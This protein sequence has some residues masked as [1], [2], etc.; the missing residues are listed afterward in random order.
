MLE[1]SKRELFPVDWS[2]GKTPE[3][4]I[5][6]LLKTKWLSIQFF[7]DGGE[8]GGAGGEGG[9]QTGVDLHGDADRAAGGSSSSDDLSDVIYGIGG[10]GGAETPE[11][12]DAG[13]QN[14]EEPEDLDAE[15]E[16]LIAKD[17]K[18]RAI[19]E[20]KV[21][22]IV[23]SRLRSMKQAQSPKV[24]TE[25]DPNVSAMMSELAKKYKVDAGDNAAIAK[26]FLEDADRLE[27][28]AMARGITT[29][30]LKRQKANERELDGYREKEKREKAMKAIRRKNE[31]ARARYDGWVKDAAELK[32]LYPSFDL[33]NEVKNRE[34]VRRLQAGIPMRE[35]YEGMHHADLVTSAMAYTAGKVEKGT[36]DKIRANAARPTEGAARSRASTVHKQNVEDLTGHDIREILKRVEGG[37]KISF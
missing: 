31:E 15:F 22:N 36:A 30:E 5:M 35:V 28:E 26:A 25:Q 6:V 2:G 21:Q 19:Y 23:S 29:D 4:I 33:G 12:P 17:G 11:D 8:G 3:G 32:K 24:Q 13:D 9:T 18:F 37:A 1:V 7:A 10:D 34:F 27:E 14:V 16:A 20:K